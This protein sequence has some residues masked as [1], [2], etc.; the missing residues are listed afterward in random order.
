MGWTR[1]LRNIGY[2]SLKTPTPFKSQKIL[3]NKRALDFKFTPTKRRLTT[4]HLP[5]LEPVLKPAL[6]SY[7]I[8]SNSL[9][10]P[11]LTFYGPSPRASR[12]SAIQ[13]FLVKGWYLVLLIS[14]NGRFRKL[15]NAS[16]KIYYQFHWNHN[17]TL[18]VK[19]NVDHHNQWLNKNCSADHHF[20]HPLASS[21]NYKTQENHHH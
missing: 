12:G 5:I 19:K 1:D 7:P 18:H 13:V 15:R 10:L 8:Y 4:S 16:V 21:F 6:P 17:V 20:N 2:P 14:F 9:P 3:F 11:S